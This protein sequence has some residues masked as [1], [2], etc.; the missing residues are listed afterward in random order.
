MATETLA[1]RFHVSGRVQ[2]VG[3][4]YFAERVALRLGVAGYV[5]N[6]PD[7][8]VEVYALCS[9]AQLNALRGELRRGPMLA[10]VDRVD[11]SEAEALAKY[12][13]SFT[14]ETEY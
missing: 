14:I 9:A 5:K 2:G 1:K 8:R 4:R 11:E 12:A 10:R 13:G 7:G 6:L 3:F